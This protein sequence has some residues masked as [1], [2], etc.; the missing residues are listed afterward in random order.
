[1]DIATLL[2][3]VSKP[4]QHKGTTAP[5]LGVILSVARRESLRFEGRTYL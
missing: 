4:L 2:F 1:M 5:K 3:A